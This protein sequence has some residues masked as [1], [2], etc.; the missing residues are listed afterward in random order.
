MA[1]N[2]S[3]E[4]DYDISYHKRAAR[5]ALTDLQEHIDML[6]NFDFWDAELAHEVE[7]YSWKLTNVLNPT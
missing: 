1:L 3:I 4:R 6:A 7:Y 2:R 5:K